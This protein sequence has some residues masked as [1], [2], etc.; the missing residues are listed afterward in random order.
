MVGSPVGMLAGAM[1]AN[2]GEPW[3]KNGHR[4]LKRSLAF[5]NEIAATANMLCRDEDKVRQAIKMYRQSTPGV[6]LRQAKEFIE[7]VQRRAGV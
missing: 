7:A 4:C 6:G 1:G 3:F 2:S 5:G